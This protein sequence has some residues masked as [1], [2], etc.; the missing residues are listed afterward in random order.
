M[1]GL[2]ENMF[3]EIMAPDP[4]ADPES[5]DPDLRD[6][7][8]DRLTDMEEL[9]PFK[10]AV[11][12]SNIDRTQM[13][14]QRSRGRPS[15]IMPG[16]RKRNWGR[17]QLWRWLYVESPESGVTPLVYQW[18]DEQK[19][20]QDRAPNGCE[21]VGIEINSQNYKTLLVQMTTL[22]VEATL[23][24]KDEDSLRFNLSCPNGDITFDHVTLPRTYKPRP[25]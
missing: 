13:L 9:T 25:E 1:V 14:L 16:S 15:A 21:F 22:Q 8:Y 24:G 7:I 23:D 3:L 6:F 20:P 11:G 4:D 12:T 18:D 5:V 2:G 19:S 10:W 17:E